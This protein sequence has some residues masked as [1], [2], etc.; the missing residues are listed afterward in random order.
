L[1][2]NPP[3]ASEKTENERS[4]MRLIA[5]GLGPATASLKPFRFSGRR[6]RSMSPSNLPRIFRAIQRTIV[7][8]T[9]SF[10]SNKQAAGEPALTLADFE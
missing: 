6:S 1:Q 2:T 9:A 8:P 5:P 3:A 10:I 7:C 4:L